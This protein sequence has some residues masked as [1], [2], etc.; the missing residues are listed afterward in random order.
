MGKN[1]P[2]EDAEKVINEF[3]DKDDFINCNVQ[4]KQTSVNGDF[5]D[6]SFDLADYWEQCSQIV[7]S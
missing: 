6:N 4:M 1:I 2:L 3:P 7:N 5:S